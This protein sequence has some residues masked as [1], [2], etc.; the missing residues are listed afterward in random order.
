MKFYTCNDGDD[1]TGI[2]AA[3]NVDEAWDIL[4]DY[5]GAGDIQEMKDEGWTVGELLIPEKSGIIM[6][7]CW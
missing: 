1:Y 2:I 7:N 5:Y 6:T 3:S 4:V